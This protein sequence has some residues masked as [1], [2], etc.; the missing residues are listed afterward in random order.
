[1]GFIVQNMHVRI[2]KGLFGL[3]SRHAVFREALGGIAGVPF[4]ANQLREIR[5]HRQ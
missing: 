1:M 5:V 3:L 4:K 2:G